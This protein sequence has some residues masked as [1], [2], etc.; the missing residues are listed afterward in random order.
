MEGIRGDLTHHLQRQL[1]HVEVHGLPKQSGAQSQR[2]QNAEGRD[3]CMPRARTCGRAGCDGVDEVAGEHRREHVR[4]GGE[5][6]KRRNDDNAPRLLSPVPEGEAED[7]LERLPAKVEFFSGH[8]RQPVRAWR[9]GVP[10][11]S[12]MDRQSKRA[13]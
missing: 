8:L 4:H 11:R 3:G 13:A 12:E 10:V 9:T 1:D 5:H 6:D 2:G 7:I